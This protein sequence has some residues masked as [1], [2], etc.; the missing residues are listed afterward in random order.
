MTKYWANSRVRLRSTG[1]YVCLYIGGSYLLSDP[2]RSTQFQTDFDV[3]LPTR[4]TSVIYPYAPDYL[5]TAFVRSIMPDYPPPWQYNVRE[6][7]YVKLKCSSIG[8]A[9]W[10]IPT[11][12]IEQKW[13]IWPLVFLNKTR[14]YGKHLDYPHMMQGYLF[15]YIAQ[16]GVVGHNIKWGIILLCTLTSINFF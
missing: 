7:N 14:A 5:I 15:P 2:P 16:E 12:K 9:S 8:H 1:G 6:L 13:G 4:C 3:L 11:L 10:S